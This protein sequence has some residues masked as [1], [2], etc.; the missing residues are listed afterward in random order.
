[1]ALPVWVTVIGMIGIGLVGGARFAATPA[2]LV[3][4]CLGA[5]L[6]SF[7][8]SLCIAAA[9]AALASLLMPEP[10][11]DITVAYLPGAIDAMM[12]LALALDLD[13]IFVGAHHLARLF[14]LSLALPFVIRSVRGRAPRVGESF[15]SPRPRKPPD[16][17]MPEH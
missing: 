9:F 8:I 2:R 15:C 1:V 14:G 6:G 4:A 17:R 7:A 11:A 5:A 12:V 13:P 3:L 16:E 10:T